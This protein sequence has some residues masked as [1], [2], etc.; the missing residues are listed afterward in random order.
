MQRFAV[1]GLGRFGTHLARALT[2]SGAEVIAIDKDRAIVE[3]ISEEVTVAVRMDS[4]DEDALR[5]QGIDKV[6]VAIVGIGQ[7][8]EANILTTVTLKAIGV[9]RIIARAERATHGQILQRI[10]ADEII[11]PE[12]ESATRWSFK[13]MAPRIGEKLEFGPGFSLGKYSAPKSFDG[14]TVQTLQLRKRFLINLVGIRKG[15][16]DNIA[17]DKKL[18]RQI[19]NVPQPDSIIN[20]GDLLWV[21]GS[22]E[23]LSKLPDK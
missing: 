17:K 14:K 2:K 13:L 5:A 21:I 9:K 15:D 6:D 1:I 10:G 22:D 18:S 19:I 4:M 20:Q 11:F 8:F 7:D 23:D 12:H 16:N 3:K